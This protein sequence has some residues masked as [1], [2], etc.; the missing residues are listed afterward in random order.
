MRAFVAVNLPPHERADITAALAPL[1]DL[2]A[3]VRW[4]PCESLHLTLEFLGSISQVE[5]ERAEAALASAVAGV[6]PFALSLGGFGCFPDRRR[7]SVWWIG[8][9]PTAPLRSLHSRVRDGLSAAG[10]ETD[11][12]PFHPHVTVARTRNARDGACRALVE[13]SAT[14]EFGVAV[15]VRSIELMRSDTLPTGARYSPVATF[16]LSH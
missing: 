9:E 16:P 13:A 1:R 15:E 8:V 12:R 3:A 10:F 11:A 7:P 4:V 2:S 5:R 14:F 6:E